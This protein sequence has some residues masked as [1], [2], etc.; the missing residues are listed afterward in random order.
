MRS[1]E[2][3]QNTTADIWDSMDLS[4]GMKFEMLPIE[5]VKLPDSLYDPK[6][7]VAGEDPFMSVLPL[8]VSESGDGLF[9]IIDGCK[10]FG[11][12]REKGRDMVPCGILEPAPEPV[13]RGLMRI[14][15]NRGRELHICEKINFLSWLKDNVKMRSGLTAASFLGI[16]SGEMYDIAPLCNAGDRVVDAVAGGL[17]HTRNV[18]DFLLLSP[19]DREVFIDVFGAYKLSMQTQREFLTWLIETASSENT[20]IESV[21]NEISL[22]DVLQDESLNAPQRIERVRN[23]LYAR[24]FPELSKTEKSWKMATRAVNPDP[25]KIFFEHYPYFEK[26]RLTV[27]VCIENPKEA[28]DFFTQLSQITQDIW[29]KIICPF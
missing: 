21:L 28:K 4:A 5:T 17:L 18:R 26:D 3:S 20:G 10:R 16:S 2:E 8:I 6:A 7:A 1:T 22:Q 15:L 25:A 23:M 19:H 12:F 11:R 13:I 24:R 9:T 14:Y 29:N 27:K